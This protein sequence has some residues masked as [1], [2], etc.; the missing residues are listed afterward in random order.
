[1]TSGPSSS[2]SYAFL[3][4]LLADPKQVCANQVEVDISFNDRHARTSTRI[5]PITRYA[6]VIGRL[7]VS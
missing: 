1:M 4:L 7:D 2:T 6:L 5:L 3:D